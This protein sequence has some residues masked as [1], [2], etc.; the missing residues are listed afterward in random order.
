MMEIVSYVSIRFEHSKFFFNFL[1]PCKDLANLCH[2]IVRTNRLHE[3][4]SAQNI[5][6]EILGNLGRRMWHLP[7]SRDPISDR[8]IN[9]RV[10]RQSFVIRFPNDGSWQS[11][12]IISKRN[13]SIS[14]LM[15]E[16][17]ISDCPCV[18]LTYTVQNWRFF[19]PVFSDRWLTA[20]VLFIT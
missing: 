10:P 6:L 13:Y 12:K 17:V 16:P 14:T 19:Q 11:N 2:T 18:Q 15:E 1:R 20:R 9:F 8:N 5:S 4:N 3:R 7:W